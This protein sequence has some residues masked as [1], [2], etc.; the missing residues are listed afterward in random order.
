MTDQ[1]I[2][3]TRKFPVMTEIASGGIGARPFLSLIYINH[4]YYKVH[5][6]AI[7]EVQ[8]STIKILL[9]V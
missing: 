8:P 6:Q 3:G 1:A 5:D 2:V 7:L 4:I 9:D